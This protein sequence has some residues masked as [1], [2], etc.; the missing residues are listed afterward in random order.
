MKFGKNDFLW[1]SALIALSAI[2]IETRVGLISRFMPVLIAVAWTA[3]YVI[4]VIRNDRSA[5]QNNTQQK[6]DESEQQRES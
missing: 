5:Q 6:E 1:L 2:T 3:A 4:W